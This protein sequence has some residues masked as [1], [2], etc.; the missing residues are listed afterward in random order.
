[1]NG[2]T[3]IDQTTQLPRYKDNNK[4]GNKDTVAEQDKIGWYNLLLGRMGKNWTDEQREKT[5]K[6]WTIAI[7]AK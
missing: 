6:R 3:T 4:F 1:L 7:I 2:Y 5:G